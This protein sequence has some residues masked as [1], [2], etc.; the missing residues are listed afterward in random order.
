MPRATLALLALPAL[1]GG[2]ART[3]PP[4]PERVVINDNRLAAG[5]L[6]VGVLTV[7]LEAREGEWHPDGD[8]DPG[9][10]VRAFGESGK[11]LRIPGP[12]LRV[13]EGTEI[14]A[15]VRNALADSTLT[16]HGLSTRGTSVATA[17]DTI[18]IGPGATLPL[19]TRKRTESPCP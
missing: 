18:Q 12:L 19:M 14:H 15:F 11:P 1:L 10:V 16:I 8:G 5:T 2:A 9:L 4:A 6:R 13:A 17:A 3:S 7:R